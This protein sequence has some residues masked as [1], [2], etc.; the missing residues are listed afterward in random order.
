MNSLSNA[1]VLLCEATR[2]DTR[3]FFSDGRIYNS[4]LS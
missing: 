2:A 3:D 1:N 4:N